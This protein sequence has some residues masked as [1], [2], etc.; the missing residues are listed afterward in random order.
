MPRKGGVPENLKPFKKGE[1]G[2]LKGRPK[3][4]ERLKE[5]TEMF[6]AMPREQLLKMVTNNSIKP[7]T[8]ARILMYLDEQFNGKAR[9]S[10]AIGGDP[11]A[12]PV[13]TVTVRP[14]KKDISKI[15]GYLGRPK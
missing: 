9:Q 12:P 13:Q 14:T 5:L 4:D 7:E 11:E 1:S 2:N 10:V 8:R 15:R 3:K 6:G